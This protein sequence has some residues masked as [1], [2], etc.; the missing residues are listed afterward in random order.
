MFALVFGLAQ[1]IF[2]CPGQHVCV[3]EQFFKILH[4]FCREF[5]ND[6]TWIAAIMI[7]RD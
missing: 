5:Y 2:P 4:L 3:K 7:S 1:Q 6:A